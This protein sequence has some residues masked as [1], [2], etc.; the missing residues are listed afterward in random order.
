[1]FLDLGILAIFL[2]ASGF[3]SGI[4]IA[5]LS[6]DRLQVEVERK[7][8]NRSGRILADFLDHPADFL[9]TTLV[10]NNIVLV[11]L[12]ILAGEFLL[13]YCGIDSEGSVVG[14]IQ[15]TL[16]T[17]VV[18]LIMGEFLPKVSFQINA[19]GILFLFA[20]PLRLISW[21]LTP[22]VWVMVRTSNL[23]INFLFRMPTE[24]SEQVFTRHDLNHF[25]TS[26]GEDTEDIDT[27]LFQK[28]LY[29]HT[30][31]VRDCMIPR[32]EIQGIDIS[33]SVDAAR[34]MFVESRHSRL[35]VYRDSLDYIEGYIHHQRLFEQ[36]Q[37]IKSMLW[38][39][40]MVTEFMPVQEV[41]NELIRQKL[42][43]AWVVDEH[44]GTAGIIAIEDILEE[45]FGEIADEHDEDEDDQQISENEFIFAGRSE[46]NVINE[47]YELDIPESSD[48]Y[49]TLSG[50]MVFEKADIPEQGEKIVLNHYQFIAEEVSNTR[51]EKVRVIRLPELDD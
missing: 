17:T 48:D 15:A 47:E 30:I 7:K 45:I 29:M 36:P 37:T 38:R 33:E 46:I 23:I 6:A 2:I 44:G 35:L 28:A 16:I 8:G 11:I 3:F 50:L 25:I 39:I 22:L 4:E 14:T 32:N 41:M 13:D 34:A 51:I 40:P 21:I 26:I 49:Q 9:G 27:A 19:T 18:V 10:G 5:F 20:Y 12:S 24:S 31:K 1:M 42:N 43:L